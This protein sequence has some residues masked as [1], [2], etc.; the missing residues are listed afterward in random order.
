[1]YKCSV[2]GYLTYCLNGYEKHL[3]LHKGK[4]SA[5]FKCMQ[6]NCSKMFSSY[7]VFRIH[8][9]RFHCKSNAVNME[10]NIYKCQT[11]PLE[12]DN[13]KKIIS[14]NLTHI[15]NKLQIICPFG[16]C[17]KLFE[18]KSSFKVHVYRHHSKSITS[19]SA[20]N[21]TLNHTPTE[22]IQCDPETTNSQDFSL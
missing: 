1:M 2:C 17:K 11:C 9:Y 8:L 15:E 22:N 20:E 5:S 4:R 6:P 3:Y 7:H 21:I 18:A 10:S 12:T 13:K 16:S 19:N 14:H